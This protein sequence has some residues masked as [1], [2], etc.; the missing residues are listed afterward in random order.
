MEV[1]LKEK[2]MT[3]SLLEWIR[4]M[5]AKDT[6][7]R[8]GYGKKIST[9]KHFRKSIAL[10]DFQVDDMSRNEFITLALFRDGVKDTKILELA[11]S[12]PIGEPLIAEI[13][14]SRL[15]VT[16]PYCNNAM[17]W[18]KGED[19]Y[20]MNCLM[21]SNEG[22]PRP[23]SPPKSLGVVSRL[24]EK[25]KRFSERNYLIGE[26]PKDIRKENKEIKAEEGK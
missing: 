17:A 20:C 24:L 10:K 12:E 1:G 9:N 8:Y 14:H 18:E 6:P 3:M 4:Q 22:K 5:K 16:C 19:F 2:D 11:L 7:H 25:R 21:V 26:T 13:N 23:V 15:L